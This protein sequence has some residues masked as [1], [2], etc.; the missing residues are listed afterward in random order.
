VRHRKKVA[1]EQIKLI[2]E[3]K[4]IENNKTAI[5]HN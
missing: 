4:L 2:K 3:K 1:I 5:E